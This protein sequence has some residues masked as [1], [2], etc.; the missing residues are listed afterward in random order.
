MLPEEHA[1]TDEEADAVGRVTVLRSNQL[2]HGVPFT[3]IGCACMPHQ[4]VT[5]EEGR[6]EDAVIS[7]R[8]MT[9]QAMRAFALDLVWSKVQRREFCSS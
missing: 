5:N 9:M 4:E 6:C 3:C 1:G 7:N 2:S 8:Y